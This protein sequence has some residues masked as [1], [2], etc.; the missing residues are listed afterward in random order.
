MHSFAYI[1]YKYKSEH[2]MNPGFKLLFDFTDG[3]L[4]IYF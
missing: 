2:W 1:S 4:D 3:I